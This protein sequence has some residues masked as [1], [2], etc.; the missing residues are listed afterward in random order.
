MAMA[1]KN[2]KQADSVCHLPIFETSDS[3]GCA[4]GGNE[5]RPLIE[6]AYQNN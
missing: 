4:A 6:F 5:L 3:L 2:K 1:S